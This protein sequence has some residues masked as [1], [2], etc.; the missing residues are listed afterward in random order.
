MKRGQ[1]HNDNTKNKISESM[2]VAWQRVQSNPASEASRRSSP[3]SVDETAVIG[4]LNAL[5]DTQFYKFAAQH[6]ARRFR[7]VREKLQSP[8]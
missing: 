3:A 7:E 2:K 8:Q 1:W 6:I 4:W 5:D